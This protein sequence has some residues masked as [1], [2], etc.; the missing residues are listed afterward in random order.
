MYLI[1]LNHFM[2]EDLNIQN[3]ETKMFLATLIPSGVW[4]IVSLACTSL[5]LRWLLKDFSNVIQVLNQQCSHIIRG[6]L[7]LTIP[8]CEQGEDLT[9]LIDQFRILNELQQYSN[10]NF[11]DVSK[12]ERILKYLQCFKLF[13]KLGYK[14]DKVCENIA[15][16]Y[17]S[18]EEFTNCVK[19]MQI[20]V[21]LT[22]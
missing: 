14:V 15:D 10:P 9:H 13:K 16:C 11:F 21:D 5:V 20:C 19:Y 12:P 4:F 3:R 18:L 7:D 2:T 22:I 6:D 17:E 8:D 1:A